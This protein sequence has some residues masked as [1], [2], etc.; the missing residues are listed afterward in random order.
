VA[1]AVAAA[2]EVVV[3]ATVV[4]VALS[5]TPTPTWMRACMTDRSGLRTLVLRSWAQAW[6]QGRGPEAMVVVVVV[7][8]VVVVVAACHN[9]GSTSAAAG[10]YRHLLSGEGWL[11]M[12]PPPTPVVSVLTSRTA[13]V[14][15]SS[16]SHRPR[17][18][19][20]VLVSLASS[21]LP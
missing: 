1:A 17:V 9:G 12:G 11:A 20:V 7:V 3:V 4:T 18:V 16:R 19:V 21:T 8:M 15:P 5:P 10:R 14:C 2:A 6:A 13:P